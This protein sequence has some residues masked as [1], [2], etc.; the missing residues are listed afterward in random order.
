MKADL[1][2]FLQG[3]PEIDIRIGVCGGEPVLKG[4]R[5]RTKKLYVQHRTLK[6]SVEKIADMHQL[7]VE[8]VQA[9]IDFERDKKSKIGR[10]R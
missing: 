1:T 10:R 3:H 9:A 8:Q 2:R 4:T 5:H 6:Y 7:S